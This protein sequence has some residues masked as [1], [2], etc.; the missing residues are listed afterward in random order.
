MQKDSANG[1]PGRRSRSSATERF[2]CHCHRCR[3]QCGTRGRGH[4]WPSP[5]KLRGVARHIAV[6]A[7]TSNVP[8]P[9][10]TP[11]KPNIRASY[12][13]PAGMCPIGFRIA[14]ARLRI[15]LSPCPH[16]RRP[17]P[18]RCGRLFEV[19]N[20]PRANPVG[21]SGGGDRDHGIQSRWPDVGCPMLAETTPRLYCAPHVDS[22]KIRLPAK[23]TPV[24][25]NI[26]IV[27][28]RNRQR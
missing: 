20:R 18:D 5:H 26:D 27:N 15:L 25:L 16:P 4:G 28:M 13:P 24:K 9:T 3:G 11:A 22:V 10:I 2:A 8:E 6:I 7:S 21:G 17:S 1:A 19:K 14:R 12:Q 23:A